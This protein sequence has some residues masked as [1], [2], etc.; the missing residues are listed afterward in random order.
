MVTITEA[1]LK[2]LLQHAVNTRD[3]SYDNFFALHM[4][5]QDDDTNAVQD[6][7]N[8]EELVRILGF[9][10]PEALL[11]PTRDL[12]GLEVE[13]KLN[14]LML[15]VGKAH[16]RSIVF[17]HYSGYAMRNPKGQ[18]VIFS[19]SNKK[20][21]VEKAILSA[22]LDNPTLSDHNSI[23]VVLLFDCCFSFAITRNQDQPRSRIV[24]MLSAGDTYDRASSSRAKTGS[25]TARLLLEVQARQNRGEE[26]IEMA[27]LIST[28]QQPSARLKWK[29]NYAARHGTGS[30]CLKISSP[31]D[32]NGHTVVS[33]DADIAVTF[34]VY[35]SKQLEIQD[36][37]ELMGWL[38]DTPEVRKAKLTLEA[39]KILHSKTFLIFQSSLVAF[40]RIR[41]LPG[42]RRLC[43]GEFGDTARVLKA[44]LSLSKNELEDPAS[45]SKRPPSLSPPK[46]E[47]K[48][49]APAFNGSSLAPPTSEIKLTALAFEPSSSSAPPEPETHTSALCLRPRFE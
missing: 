38:T 35:I 24:E 36:L 23:D 39:V 1:Q 16:G 29:P 9:P 6:S 46:M 26:K 43:E 30:V 45:N 19:K 15:R 42:V 11:I 27:D 21:S 2:N 33:G 8:F 28:L 48:E 25:F 31:R 3:S 44:C 17:V 34:S 22:F 14:K 47:L 40:L 10:S 20:V 18:L 4:R 41:G 13:F 49:T 5:W 7:N 32:A 12:P 37:Q